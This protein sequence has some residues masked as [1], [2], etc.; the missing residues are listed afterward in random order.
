MQIHIQDTKDKVV[1]LI[2]DMVY[3][4]QF[5]PEVINTIQKK[6]QINTKTITRGRKYG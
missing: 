6:L 3:N 4:N 5:H 1:L 2:Q